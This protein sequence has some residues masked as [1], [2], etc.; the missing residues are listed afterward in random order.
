M[1]KVVAQRNRQKGI[2]KKPKG[3][4]KKDRNS[5]C[6]CLSGHRPALLGEGVGEILEI[7]KAIIRIGPS[8][9]LPAFVWL[10][11]SSHARSAG[12]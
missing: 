12:S 9:V 1:K 11:D 6:Y 3:G 10:S 4:R 7:L 8:L 5:L 2:K